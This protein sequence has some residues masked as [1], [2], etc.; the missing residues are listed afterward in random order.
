M[1]NPDCIKTARIAALV[2]FI[3]HGVIA[4]IYQYY[5]V[6]FF[7]AMVV[8]YLFIALPAILLR[9]K[10]VRGKFT[11]I[12]G[13]A[14]T[15]P[16]IAVYVA[17][18]AGFGVILQEIQG[19]AFDYRLLSVW[20]G[21]PMLDVWILSHREFKKSDESRKSEELEPLW[22]SVLRLLP[23]GMKWEKIKNTDFGAMLKKVYFD[24]TTKQA[25][26]NKLA[27][28]IVL[29]ALLAVLEDR[30]R[31]QDV[32]AFPQNYVLWELADKI[33]KKM[34]RKRYINDTTQ[35]SLSERVENCRRVL[36]EKA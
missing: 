3:F 14:A 31:A 2:C 7:V 1:K 29:S 18:W 34:F 6:V 32:R 26:V 16:I 21:Y 5:F 15:L 36:Q 12:Q 17:L 9:Y 22:A 25:D 13:V 23:F 10:V 28:Y 27:C 8:D 19:D 11:F 35:Q 33:I 20:W 30:T 4:T 24:N